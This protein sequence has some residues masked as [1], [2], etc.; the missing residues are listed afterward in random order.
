MLVSLSGKNIGRIKIEE[1][2]IAN[3]VPNVLVLACIPLPYVSP[4]TPKIKK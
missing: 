1:K 3:G 4:G 2:I